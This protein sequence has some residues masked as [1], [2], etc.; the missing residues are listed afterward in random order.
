[1]VVIIMH[2]DMSLQAA[3]VVT[4][5]LGAQA[6][7][8]PALITTTVQAPATTLQRMLWYVTSWKMP[9]AA[10]TTRQDMPRAA[11]VVAIARLRVSQQTNQQADALTLTPLPTPFAL[12]PLQRQHLQSAQGL[13]IV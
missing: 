13:A 4:A 8:T 3:V 7:Q 11:A 12:L 5:V 9:V 10:T 1:V 6:S 2:Q